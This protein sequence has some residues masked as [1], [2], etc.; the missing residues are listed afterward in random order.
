M[1]KEN[2]FK[3]ITLALTF[4]GA[5]LFHSNLTAQIEALGECDTISGEYSINVSGLETD[6]AYVIVIDGT[7]LTTAPA[8]DTFPDADTSYGGFTFVDGTEKKE[9]LV[10]RQALSFDPDTTR[11]TVNEVLCRDIDADG[12]MDFGE[13]CDYTKAIGEGGAI[14]ST[15]APFTGDN[16]YLYIL[17]DG[18]G[19]YSTSDTSN[20]SGLFTDLENG[21]YKVFA[22]NFLSQTESDDFLSA[23]PNAT[24]L[25]TYSVAAPACY[26]L[27][28]SADYTVDC[29]SIV[30]IYV[31]PSDEMVCADEDAEFYV[32]DSFLVVPPVGAT[33]TYQWQVND[34]S[35]WAN[36]A[37]GTA[38]DSVLNLTGVT[39]ADSGNMY[40]VIV[41][42]DVGATT[43][44]MDTS[45]VGTLEVYDNPVLLANLDVTV[46]SDTI[47]G[48][49]DECAG[50][51]FRDCLNRRRIG[52]RRGSGKCYGRGDSGYE[53]YI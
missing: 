7:T 8:G 6:T 24:D 3:L 4:L 29:M 2:Q 40:R 31:N 42:M 32:Q 52:S 34:G 48:I 36:T 46:S 53:L 16:V 37:D 25:I 35:G 50:R 13:A 49:T 5:L 45:G 15:V 33:L 22:F 41:T 21:D 17:T 19:I 38:P 11:I 20:N 43:I 51:Q 18:T 26:A 30:D 27:C 1:Y 9:V 14:V 39:F 44:S 28:G 10:I 23:I 47:T 12:T